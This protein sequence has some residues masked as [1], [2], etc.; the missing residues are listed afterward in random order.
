MMSDPATNLSA[1][2]PIIGGASRRPAWRWV[3]LAAGGLLGVVLALLFRFDPAHHAFYPFCV[4]HRM[5]GLQCPGCGGLR[6]VHHLLH[7]EIWT[8]FRYNELVVLG[9]PWA[10]WLIVRR[11]RHGPGPRKMSPRQQARWGWIAVAVL[12]GFWIVRNLPLEMFKLPAG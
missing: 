5:T 12:I 6:A 10:A 9:A 1:A 2:P 8:A 11:W 7:G 4:F 3:W